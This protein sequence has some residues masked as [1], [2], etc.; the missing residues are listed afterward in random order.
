MP[1]Q[2]E[3]EEVEFCSEGVILS[4]T[5]VLPKRVMAS[6]VLV[7]GSGQEKRMTALSEE[8]AGRGIATLTYDKRGIGK[9][10]GVYAGPEVGTNNISA[11]NLNLL[12]SD[13]AAAVKE[14][15]QWFPSNSHVPVGMMGGSQ[16][17][18]IIPLAAL[19][20][21]HVQFMVIWSGPMV[22]AREQLRF[23]FYTGGQ[24]D[25][26]DSHTEDEARKHI[27]SDPDLFEFVDTDPLESLRKLSI[28]ALWLY[29][30]CDS[31][32]PVNLSIER[33]HTQ[34]VSGKPYKYVVFPRMGHFLP[35]ERVIPVT[36][37][38]LNKQFF[39]P[40][41]DLQVSC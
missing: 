7:H 35:T 34:I 14:L 36:V 24:V 12:A 30:G 1:S 26:W 8:L 19:R 6:I 38:W 27:S 22:T 2:Y 31:N 11:K 29:G 16:A 9:S 33:L 25:F 13:A 41:I 3:L 37:D 39:S 15:T 5:V 21:S 28:P 32:V 23:Q 17:G 20:S 10:E 40:A 18:W 4:G